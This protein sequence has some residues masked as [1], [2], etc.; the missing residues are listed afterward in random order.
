MAPAQQQQAGKLLAAQGPGHPTKEPGPQNPL[1]AVP[2]Q[3]DVG[4]GPACRTIQEAGLLA[5]PGQQG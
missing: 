2:E 5:G 1:L 3:D 4:L